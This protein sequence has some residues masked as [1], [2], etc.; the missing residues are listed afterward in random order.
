MDAPV[1]FALFLRAIPEKRVFTTAYLV[2]VKVA[3]PDEPLGENLGVGLEEDDGVGR[4]DVRLEVARLLHVRGVPV[5]QEA[6]QQ[7]RE[8]NWRFGEA[9]GRICVFNSM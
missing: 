2:V 6:L 1:P 9:L 8:V 5:D 7:R 3:A 4:A